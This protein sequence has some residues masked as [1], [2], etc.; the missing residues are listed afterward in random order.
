MINWKNWLGLAILGMVLA[1]N[2]GYHKGWHDAIEWK[3][4]HKP[5]LVKNSLGNCEEAIDH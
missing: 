1:Y 3:L 5:K 4:Q 2:G